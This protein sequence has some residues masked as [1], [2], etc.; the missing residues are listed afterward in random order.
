MKNLIQLLFFNMVME[1]LL[2]VDMKLVKQSV[3]TSDNGVTYIGDRDQIKRKLQE[4]SDVAAQRFLVQIARLDLEKKVKDPTK[5]LQTV[6][7]KAKEQV[8]EEVTSRDIC[9]TSTTPSNARARKAWNPHPHPQH[10]THKFKPLMILLAQDL[11]S[12]WES[13]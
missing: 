6:T 7:A 8:T 3:M 13:H 11:S 10:Q 4:R 2:E 5:N 12:L 1:K 9:L